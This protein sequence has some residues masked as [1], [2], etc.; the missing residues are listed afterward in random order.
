MS[1]WRNCQ[2]DE[3]MLNEYGKVVEE[4]WLKTPRLRTRVD[5]DEFVVLPNHLHATIVIQEGQRRCQW[6]GHT[7]GQW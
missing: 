5:V 6:Q 4:E 2:R 7:A 1:V 3:V